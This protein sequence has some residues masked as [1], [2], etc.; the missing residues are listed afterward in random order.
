MNY[1]YKR[2][3]DLVDV[4]DNDGG[5]EDLRE[6]SSGGLDGGDHCCAVKVDDGR[7]DEEKSNA[8]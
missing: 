4:A 2:V 1:I 5:E 8:K 3:S 6:R 7:G